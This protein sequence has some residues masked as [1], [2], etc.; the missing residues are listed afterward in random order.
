M[1]IDACEDNYDTFLFGFII[2][3]GSWK[4]NRNDGSMY[5]NNIEGSLTHD[6]NQFKEVLNVL[7]FKFPDC[8]EVMD[9]Q[10]QEA[11]FDLKAPQGTLEYR[12]C[13]TKNEELGFYIKRVKRLDESTPL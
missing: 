3:S 13:L 2:R 5:L 7:Y 6:Y 12:L 1:F 8:R 11:Y 4:C 10:K 9:G